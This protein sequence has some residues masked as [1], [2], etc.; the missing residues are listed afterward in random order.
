MLSSMFEANGPMSLEQH[1]HNAKEGVRFDPEGMPP[2]QIAAAAEYSIAHSLCAIAELLYNQRPEVQMPESNTA[3]F[4][5]PN[6]VPLHSA[7]ED[8]L[9]KRSQ[10]SARTIEMLEFVKEQDSEIWQRIENNEI[11]IKEA[12]NQVRANLAKAEADD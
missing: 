1:M 8:K 11:T 9:N 10:L 2:Q 6:A 7:I 4:V 5:M 12:Y 3:E